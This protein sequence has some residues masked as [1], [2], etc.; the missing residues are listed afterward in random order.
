MKKSGDPS[1]QIPFSAETLCVQWEGMLEKFRDQQF[2]NDPGFVKLSGVH[3]FIMYIM[4]KLKFNDIIH[5]I[6]SANIM[7]RY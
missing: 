6:A 2:P 4:S 1:S 5:N 3:L 7:A